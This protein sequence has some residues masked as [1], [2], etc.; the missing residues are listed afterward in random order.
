MAS[1]DP[2]C[3]NVLQTEQLAFATGIHDSY[4]QALDRLDR[5]AALC[6]SCAAAVR[7]WIMGESLQ[8]Y[9]CSGPDVRLEL[10]DVSASASNA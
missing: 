3:D 2:W 1:H 8:S 4:G 7:R 9:G 6:G 5:R 10:C